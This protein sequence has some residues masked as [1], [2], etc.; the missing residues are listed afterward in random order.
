MDHGSPY[1]TDHVINQVRSW[2][3]KPSFAFVEHPQNAA[4]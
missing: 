4:S 3:I 2:G 1:L